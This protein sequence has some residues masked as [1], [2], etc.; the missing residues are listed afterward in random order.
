MLELELRRDGE[1]G[2]GSSYMEPF[3]P[4]CAGAF[5]AQP[6]PVLPFPTGV[7][8]PWGAAGEAASGAAAAECG[9]GPGLTKAGLFTEP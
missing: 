8:W 3:T 7:S 9:A 4:P 1:R 6:I 5:L 2:Q